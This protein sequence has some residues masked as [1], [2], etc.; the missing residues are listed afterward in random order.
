[1]LSKYRDVL[2]TTAVVLVVHTGAVVA[3]GP[4]PMPDSAALIAAS[5]AG[6][7]A[8]ARASVS[9]LR[10]GS[11]AATVI[12][13]P[14]VG[15]VGALVVAAKPPREVPGAAVARPGYAADSATAQR[16]REAYRAAYLPRRRRAMQR[17]V[18]VGTGVFAFL[19]GATAL[20]Y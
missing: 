20:A 9:G 15:G 18:L 11:G 2:G 14:L 4:T 17:A 8:G 1:V 7:A 5:Q 19:V 13:S 10:W 16:Y 6:A 12:F 3:Q